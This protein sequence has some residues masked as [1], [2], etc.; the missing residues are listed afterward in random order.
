[1]PLIDKLA[2]SK[3][4]YLGFV[5][6]PFEII[7]MRTIPLMTDCYEINSSLDNIN[8]ISHISNQLDKG[9]LNL[10]NLVHTLSS[11]AEENAASTEET[12]ASAI[13]VEN[14]T[15]NIL[16]STN[17]LKNVSI[18]LNTTINKFKV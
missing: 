18:A 16:E 11:I 17:E 4:K 15:Q 9:R 10:V 5:I 1:M 2:K 12:S 8:S 13:E 3:F 6:A 7:F 14:M